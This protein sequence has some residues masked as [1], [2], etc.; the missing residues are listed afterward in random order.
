MD[1]VKVFLMHMP[2]LLAQILFFNL[3]K[4][5]IIFG[6]N[7]PL[8]HKIIGQLLKVILLVVD[9]YMENVQKVLQIKN[10]N[11]FSIKKKKY[12]MQYNRFMFNSALH[13]RLLMKLYVR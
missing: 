13:F 4:L 11:R 1:H 3:T 5:I 6:K 10:Q 12:F 2:T 9:S 8:Y 7:L